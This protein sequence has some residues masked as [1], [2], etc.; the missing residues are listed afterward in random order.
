[1][2]SRNEWLELIS[3]YLDGGANRAES[4]E[5]EKALRS[6]AS[7]RHDFLRCLNVDAVMA[8]SRPRIE[9]ASASAVAQKNWTRP[10]WWALAAAALV[11]LG[12]VLTLFLRNPERREKS[13]P[14]F[15]TLVAANDAVWADPNIELALR[16]GE[17][18]SSLLQIESGTAEFKCADGASVIVRGPAAVRF[19]ERKRV[20]V[21]NGQVFCRC[22]SPASRLTIATPATEVVDLGTEFA[23]EARADL[24]T[25]VA[26]VSGEV[27]VGKT[28]PRRLKKGEAV[29]VRGDGI[30]A[31]RPMPRE[32][33]AEL[34]LASPLLG[35]VLQRG[36]NLLKEPHFDQARGDGVWA[37]TEGNFEWTPRGRSGGGMRVRAHGSAHWPQCHQT[38]DAEGQE[39]RLVVASVW[40][41]SA[42]DEPLRGRQTAMLKV[43]FKNAEGRDFAFAMQRFLGPGSVPGRFEQVELAA[44]IPPGTKR[45]QM[46][47][48]LQSDL[49]AAGSVVF[50]DASLM[51]TAPKPAE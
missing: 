20:F 16:S 13:V 7:L 8:S 19:P 1:M 42:P 28:Q 40:A 3:R 4:Q 14:A 23:V 47:L 11:M 5:L 31:I 36:T 32:E 35:D 27:Q 21:Q 33:F 30:L 25:R 39:G 18:P 2:K 50:D 45:I 26:V 17:L 49:K 10:V 41:A 12:T 24:S 37:G 46:Q 48:M 22:P 51:I 34:L 15:A 44:V 9:L 43:A 6:D 29:E 38:L